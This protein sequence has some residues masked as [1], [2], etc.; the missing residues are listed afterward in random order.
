[1]NVS[2]KLLVSNEKQD[3]DVINLMK[4]YLQ[5]TNN[6]NSYDFVSLITPRGKYQATGRDNYLRFFDSYYDIIKDGKICALAEKQFYTSTIL[7]DMDYKEKI[8]SETEIH[9]LYDDD[10]IK[11]VVDVYSTI[12][13]EIFPK[14]DTSCIVLTKDPYEKNGFVKN[15]FHIQFQRVCTYEST[16]K[17]IYEKAKVILG[18]NL[19]DVSTKPW[20]LYGCCKSKNSGSYK[21]EYCFNNKGEKITLEEFLS[22]HV[23]HRLGGLNYKHPILKCNRRYTPT[24]KQ[25]P[26]VLSVWPSNPDY[27][28][29]KELFYH[30]KVIEKQNTHKIIEYSEKDKNDCIE[31][32]NHL[33]KYRAEGYNNWILVLSVIKNV[34]GEN[35]KGLELALSFSSKCPEKFV[36]EEVEKAYFNIKPSKYG[37]DVIGGML[38]ADSCKIKQM[39]YKNKRL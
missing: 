5:Y 21:V 33:H 17:Y 18:E 19:D 36:E 38:N 24:I 15:G 1:M 35:E 37:L 7:V 26:W 8:A 2:E 3:S 13:K 4:E 39:L 27:Y 23:N 14:A 20:L 11:R 30:P 34:F 16:R 10:D 6:N 9:Y 12:I 29:E 25:L 22:T 28:Y 31:I 32:V